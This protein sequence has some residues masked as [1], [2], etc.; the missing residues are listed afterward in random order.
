[1]NEH[2]QWLEKCDARQRTFPLSWKEAYFRINF[3]D[4]LGGYACPICKKV[5]RGTRGFAQLRGDHIYPFSKGGLTIW[6]NFQLLCVKCN[7]DKWN[8]VLP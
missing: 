2:P 6:Q 7:R 4:E 3:N 1:M 5:F 8:Y